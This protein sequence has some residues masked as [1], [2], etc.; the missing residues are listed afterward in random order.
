MLVALVRIGD[1]LGWWTT[2]RDGQLLAHFHLGWIGYGTLT[3]AGIGS[4][5]LPAFLGLAEHADTQAALPAYRRLGWLLSIGLL[6]LAVGAPF[7]WRGSPGPARC[8]S[9]PGW[10]CVAV[11]TGY[12]LRRKPGPSTSLAAIRA[13][14]GRYAGAW[15]LGVGVALVRPAPPRLWTAYGIV[16]IAGWLT[17]IIVGVMHRIGPRLMTAFL[18]RRGGGLTLAQRGGQVLDQRLAWG[19]VV[20]LAGGL[21]IVTAGVWPAPAVVGAGSLLYLI[22]ASLVGAQVVRLVRVAS[23]AS[24]SRSRR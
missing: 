8:S 12:F 16:A 17:L 6:A 2:W 11:L 7:G 13:A 3:V 9:Q 18:A 21:A 10:P 15:L 1:G 14:L 23:Q 4:K 20:A 24:L 5:M 19:A 22:G